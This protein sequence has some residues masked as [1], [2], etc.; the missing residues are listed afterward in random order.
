MLSECG[1]LTNKVLF[2]SVNHPLSCSCGTTTSDAVDGS[3]IKCWQGR[4]RES[5]GGSEKSNR[6]D[7]GKKGLNV[8]GKI[9]RDIYLTELGDS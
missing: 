1:Y 9:N 7:S 4:E 3:D 2:V 5:W 6:S 8:C